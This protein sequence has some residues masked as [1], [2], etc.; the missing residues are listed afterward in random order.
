M[1]NLRIFFND[2]TFAAGL[3]YLWR[4]IRLARCR[5][6]GNNSGSVRWFREFP[7]KICILPREIECSLSSYHPLILRE[8]YGTSLLW[9][10]SSRVSFLGFTDRRFVTLHVLIVLPLCKMYCIFYVEKFPLHLRN[11]P[12]RVSELHRDTP[13]L[14]SENLNI[15][16]KSLIFAGKH[17]Q[18]LFAQ[19]QLVLLFLLK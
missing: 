6:L 17:N 7:P 5:I 1:D 9:R 16:V 3:D 18:R 14:D 2:I 12:S 19:L 8:S 15:F 10:S 11:H 4:R 13:L